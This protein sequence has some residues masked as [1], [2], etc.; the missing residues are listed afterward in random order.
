MKIP[1]FNGNEDW[2]M[3]ISRF[4]AIA[5]RYR[6]SDDDKLDQLLPRLEGVA[7]QFVFSQLSRDILYDY[8]ELI[9]EINSR[10][11]VV[12]TA[13]SFA[14]KFS[15]RNQRHG[16]TAEDYA[17]DLKRLYDKAHGYRDRRTRD[18]DLVRRFLDGLYDEDVRF[19]VEFHKEPRNID[20]AVYQV[21]NLIQIRSSCRGEKRNRN[22]IRRAQDLRDY[23]YTSGCHDDTDDRP[24]RAYAVNNNL[25]NRRPEG[26]R[27]ERAWRQGYKGKETEHE[28]KTEGYH[29]EQSSHHVDKEQDTEN[30]MVMSVLL[31]IRDEMRKNRSRVSTTRNDVECYSCHQKGHYARDCPHRAAN[32]MRD[33][34]AQRADDNTHPLNY[35]GPALAAKGGS[36]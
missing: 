22:N 12:E 18:E 5:H 23:E 11:R 15:R 32:N 10:F 28:K 9:G 2:G 25:P 19:E 16:E 13:Q 30:K 26:Y 33:M 1:S 29:R 17:A 21:I 20:E 3:W 7:G 24:E 8:S 35:Q 34:G 6:W 36:K 27:K 31:E 4:E 14:A